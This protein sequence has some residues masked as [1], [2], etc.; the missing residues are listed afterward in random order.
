MEQALQLRRGARILLVEDNIV[1]QEVAQMLLE[2]MG[3]R[4]VVADNGQVAVERAA[5][6]SFDLVF[7]DVQ[8]PVMDGL[9]AA[10][11]IRRLPDRHALPIL[12]MTANAFSEDR[13]QCLAAGMN[14]HIAKPIELEKLQ[15]LLLR[16]LPLR[17]QSPTERGNDHAEAAS[18][19]DLLHRLDGM[20][21][22]A[23]LR[24]LQGDSEGYLRLLLQFAEHHGEDGRLLTSLAAND[25]HGGLRQRTHA[26]KGAAATLGAWRI[27]ELAAEIERMAGTAATSSELQV[28]IDA[29]QPVLAAVCQVIAQV[30]AK[31][32]TAAPAATCDQEQAAQVLARMEALLAIEDSAVNELFVA[33]HAPLAAAFGPQ[34]GVLGRQIDA[35]DYTDALAT[36]RG[37][38]GLSSPSP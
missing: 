21:T 12:A 38:L 37:L 34:I 35:F 18:G 23:G 15:A 17:P 29:L 31:T 4:V 7:M 27:A 6:E 9:E 22:E 24:L 32:A 36:V 25:N 26:L 2:S 19:I 1:N 16:W 5:R 13:E 11:A 20:D 33:N 30:T 8:M 10:A 3:M 28:H 14:D